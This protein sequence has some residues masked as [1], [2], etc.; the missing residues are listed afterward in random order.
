MLAG[1]AGL[2]G[3]I[4]GAD[5]AAV[6][7]PV[8]AA[9]VALQVRVPAAAAAP[10]ITVTAAATTAATIRPRRLRPPLSRMTGATCAWVNST[11]S[12]TRNG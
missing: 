9:A 2:A 5:R 7:F 6:G 3:L 11:V 12:K 10:P 1:L 8:G 4:A